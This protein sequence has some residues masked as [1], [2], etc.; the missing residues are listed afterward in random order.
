MLCIYIAIG[1]FPFGEGSLLTIDLGQQ[2]VDFF[3][4]FK[5]TLTHQPDTFFYSFSKSMGGDMVGLWAYYLTSPLNL[6]FLLFPYTQLA[7]AVSLLILLKISLTSLTCC[8]LLIKKYHQTTLATVVFSISYGLMSYITVNQFNVMW[9]DG[10]MWL[11]LIVLGL[12]RLVSGKQPFLY[13]FSLSIAVFSNYYIGYMI[14][15]FLGLFYPYAYLTSEPSSNKSV[16]HFLLSFGKFIGYS[17]LSM[18]L[19]AF[20]LVPTYY[21]LI[22]GKAAYTSLSWN[23]NYD[24]NPILLLSKLYFGSFDFDQMP[25]GYP[26]IFVGSIA[27][28]SFIAAFFSKKTPLGERLYTLVL[29]IV[30][31]VS[32]NFDTLNKIWHG[33]Q[34]PIWYPYR[35][36][37]VFC[38]LMVYVGYRWFIKQESMSLLLACMLIFTAAASSIYFILFPQSYLQLWQIIIGMNFVVLV[39]YF[40][41]SSKYTQKR[42]MLVLIVVMTE[43]SLNSVV[44]ITRLSYVKQTEF[45]QYQQ[46]IQSWASLIAPSEN[47][48][49]RI[50]K[51][52]QR[53]KVDAMQMN[54]YGLN[55]FASTLETEIPT[56][57]GL[58][59]ISEGNGFVSY[60]NGTLFTD[61][62]FAVRYMIQRDDSVLNPYTTQ[63]R[64]YIPTE[65]WM[66]MDMNFNVA[67][68]Q[69]SQATIF[70]NPRMLSLA[71]PVSNDIHQVSLNSNQPIIAQEKLFSLLY[72]AASDTLYRSA[73]V[74]ITHHNLKATPANH[75]TRTTYHK[76]DTQ[77]E[78]WIEISF[79]PDS[80][81]PYYLSLDGSIGSDT[82]AIT[83]NDMEYS[84]YRAFRHTVLLNVAS[85]QQNEKQVI[86]LYLEKDTVTLNVPTV[87][88]LNVSQL[89]E[90]VQYVQPQQL[91]IQTFSPT[92]ITGT[93]LVQEDRTM[94]TTIPY[95][96]GWTV[97]V[98]GKPV[99]S[100]KM[101][102]SL[103]AF[104]ISKGEHTIELHYE[105]P[106]MLHGVLLSIASL[107]LLL[108][109][110]LVY[111]KKK[112]MSIQRYM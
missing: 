92:H 9:L 93:A 67:V 22:S 33:G 32:M 59:G 24:Y 19:I 47:E 78:A 91:N 30:L 18:G 16:V 96:I 81:N 6:I 28:F 8:V 26:N 41:V 85:Q 42:Q 66:R 61:A 1:T 38:F 95:S 54:I 14:C 68:A 4:Y 73:A 60:S 39:L 75:S 48:F 80:S 79:T 107:L 84:Y 49:Y 89:E 64:L 109:I 46:M 108:G 106:Y 71:F 86:R 77:Q 111:K 65:T 63:N 52:F 40:L 76:I 101:F 2:Y 35:F 20:L 29:T 43:L 70:E 44:N 110:V 21:S 97:H 102:K 36:S 55:T 11:P 112:T 90:M 31:I 103:L 69:Q 13:I 51:T 57:M 87:Y 15:L 105:T 25:S 5:E 82:F 98:D 62:L 10:M 17:L 83:L 99:K 12:D 74:S 37:F 23:F 7:T 56:I 94:L 3:A 34:F 58:L 27:L 45:T 72:P 104:P 53:S 88:E 100:L 50:E